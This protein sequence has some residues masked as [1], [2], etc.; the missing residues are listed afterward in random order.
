ML[1]QVARAEDLNTIVD[2][3]ARLALES[4][5]VCLDR[6]RLR[7]GVRRVLGDESLGL[8]LL[9]QEGGEPVGQLGLTYEWSDWRNG[10]FWWIQSVYVIPSR[11]RAGVLRRLHERVLELAPERGVCGL[12][13][14][15]DCENHSAKAAYRSLGLNPAGYQMYEVDFVL[16]RDSS[17]G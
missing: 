13:L 16:R 10:I 12:R 6:A 15:V 1:I 9:A 11:R 5:G 7:E 8:Y 14:Y 4:E 3:N 2:F 17:A